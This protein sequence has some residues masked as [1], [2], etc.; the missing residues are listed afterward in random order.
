M[1]LGGAFEE[2]GNKKER[3]R[4]KGDVRRIIPLRRL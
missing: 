1:K 4:E 2:I 3:G